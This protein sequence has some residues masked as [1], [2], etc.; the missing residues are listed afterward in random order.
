MN[1]RRWTRLG[2]IRSGDVLF[3]GIGGSERCGGEA[4]QRKVRRKVKSLGMAICL[5]SA[6]LVIAAPRLAVPPEGVAFG[7][8]AVGSNVVGRVE[9][10]NVGSATVSVFRVKACCGAKAGL[11][12]MKIPPNGCECCQCENVA[13]SNV[14]SFQLGIG[15][16]NWILATMA[17]FPKALSRRVR[18]PQRAAGWGEAS[19]SGSSRTARPTRRCGSNSARSTSAKG[20]RHLLFHSP[21]STRDHIQGFLT[22]LSPRFGL[23]Q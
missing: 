11:S 15:N 18:C 19:C 16:W 20:S 14:A 13:S 10:R 4:H 12:A 2:L 1:A 21:R 22:A 6:W 7:E 8:V 23:G 5:L 17:T 3:R 9:I